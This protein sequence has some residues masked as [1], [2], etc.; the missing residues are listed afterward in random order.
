MLPRIS[1][2]V[3]PHGGPSRRVSALPSGHIWRMRDA[4]ATSV[5]K[6][7]QVHLALKRYLLKALTGSS[8]TGPL[9]ALVSFVPCHFA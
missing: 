7:M 2:E 4:S 3:L 9:E 6:L 8:A 1:G 5:K